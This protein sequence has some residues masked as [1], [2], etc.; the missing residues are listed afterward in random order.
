MLLPFFFLTDASQTQLL[1][2]PA[3]LTRQNHRRNFEEP[4]AF[5]GRFANSSAPRFALISSD[6]NKPPRRPPR[7]PFTSLCSSGGSEDDFSTV[8]DDHLPSVIVTPCTPSTVES[9]TDTE[10]IISKEREHESDDS[11]CSALS[12]PF[13]ESS[14]PTGHK[15]VDSSPYELV[16][17]R[18]RARSPTGTGIGLRRGLQKRPSQVI[19]LFRT[20]KL[21]LPVSPQSVMD[22]LNPVERSN[23]SP[24]VGSTPRNFM[25]SYIFHPKPNI[26]WD[27]GPVPDQR[28]HPC[29]TNTPLAKTPKGASESEPAPGVKPETILL[30]AGGSETQ[31]SSD[32]GKMAPLAYK[33]S[34][35]SQI[36]TPSHSVSCVKKEQLDLLPYP[37]VFDIYLYYGSPLMRQ[38]S[39]QFQTSWNTTSSDTSNSASSPIPTSP[40]EPSLTSVESSPRLRPL[41]KLP[42]GLPPSKYS[43]PIIIRV[44]HPSSYLISQRFRNYAKRSQQNDHGS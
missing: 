17:H 13:L 19:E 42:S 11:S 29:T 41:D 33:Y 2:H 26:I 4:N 36:F 23:S 14:S 10:T 25:A 32:E 21:L 3:F 12:N 7:P 15:I 34:I 40:S 30:N 44:N 38:E 24:S 22:V 20:H 35:Q 1:R 27:A 18:N 43:S 9:K 16:G 28:T 8:S 39:T 31:V 6:P 37:D 5:H